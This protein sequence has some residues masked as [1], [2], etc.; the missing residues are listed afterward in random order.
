VTFT[1]TWPGSDVE[2]TLVT[3]SG[4]RI[5][6]TDAEYDVA[7]DVGA[8]FQTMTITDPEAGDWTIELKGIDIPAGEEPFTFSRVDLPG[9]HEPPDV[10]FEAS[11]RTSEGE[12]QFDATATDPVHITDY[13]WSFEDGDMAEGAT[14]SHTFP[15]PGRYAVTLL[16]IDDQGAVGTFEREIVVPAATTGGSPAAAPPAPPAPP[17]LA[18]STSALSFRAATKRVTASTTPTKD[19]SWPYTFVTTGRVVPPAYCATGVTPTAAGGNCVT[20]GAPRCVGVVTVRIKKRTYTISSRNV[21][22]RPNCTY[23]SKVSLRSRTPLRRG[24]LAVSVRFQGNASLLPKAAPTQTVRTGIGRG[25]V[26]PIAQGVGPAQR[27]ASPWL[28]LLQNG[29]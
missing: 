13:L 19:R 14:A 15:A 5:G 22:L 8:G 23:R 4:R 2:M 10:K 18:R 21:G 9:R 17:P 24:T 20:L 16:A 27:S 3:P 12:W 29:G 28:R 25:V 26:Q 7:T 1:V 6:R 11:P